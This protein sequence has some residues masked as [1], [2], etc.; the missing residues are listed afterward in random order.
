MGTCEYCKRPV[1]PFGDMS[2]GIPGPSYALLE[3]GKE[4][5]FCGVPCEMFYVLETGTSLRKT[6]GRPN[7][8]FPSDIGSEGIADPKHPGYSK[9]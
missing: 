3:D 2:R 1:S 7:E 5:A 9:N 6:D 4:I 8:A